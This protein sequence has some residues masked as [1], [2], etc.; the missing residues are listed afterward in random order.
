MQVPSSFQFKLRINI[1][2]LDPLQNDLLL[3]LQS[4]AAWRRGW[5]RDYSEKNVNLQVVRPKADIPAST[6]LGSLLLQDLD[7]MSCAFAESLGVTCAQTTNSQL[8]SEVAQPRFPS[9]CMTAE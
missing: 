3:F 4:K 2:F 6:L 7:K 9:N 1:S 8:P 5:V